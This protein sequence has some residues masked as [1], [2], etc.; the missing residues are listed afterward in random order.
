MDTIKRWE[1]QYSL[2][3][4]VIITRPGVF[5]GREGVITERRQTWYKVAVEM[6]ETGTTSDAWFY[7]Y[8]FEKGD[9]DRLVVRCTLLEW[10]ILAA[11]I[12]VIVIGYCSLI[13]IFEI[14]R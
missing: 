1:P 3:D 14:A 7:N 2:G 10:L 12:V 6:P 9:E 8:E 4:Y 13:S 11:L 5:E